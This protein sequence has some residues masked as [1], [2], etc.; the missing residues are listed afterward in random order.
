MPKKS[1]GSPG[2]GP[3]PCQNEDVTYGCG[4]KGKIAASAH[5]SVVFCNKCRSPKERASNTEKV[6]KYRER[7]RA[8]ARAAEAAA[9]KKKG[10]RKKVAA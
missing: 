1:K 7:K 9:A 4:G 8:E 5:W 3:R 2:S 10:S 6:R